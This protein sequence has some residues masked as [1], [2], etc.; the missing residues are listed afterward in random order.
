MA[1]K[2]VKYEDRFQDPENKGPEKVLWMSY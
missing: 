1:Q 2:D